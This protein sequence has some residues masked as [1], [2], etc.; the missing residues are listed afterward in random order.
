M[1]AASAPAEGQGAVPKTQSP[2]WRLWNCGTVGRNACVSTRSQTFRSPRWRPGRRM[3][4]CPGAALPRLV[5]PA[6]RSLQG[7]TI[8]IVVQAP[9]GKAGT[10]IEPFKLLNVVLVNLKTAF[11]GTH[12]AFNF[13]KYARPYL[14]E[15]PYR[16]Y[17]RSDMASM[18]PST[19]FAVTQ[20]RPCLARRIRG[21]A[22]LET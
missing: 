2:S 21:K 6:L 20:T 8:N 3:P 17:R 18:V 19:A 12:H 7:S 13:A 16:F 22:G 1:L 9:R 15:V 4:S 14:A 5:F 10:E 11:S